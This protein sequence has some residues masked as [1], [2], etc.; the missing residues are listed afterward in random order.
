MGA[1]SAGTIRWSLFIFVLAADCGSL[2][3]ANEPAQQWNPPS[4]AGSTQFPLEVGQAENL[5]H[6]GRAEQ[7]YALLYPLEGQFAGLPVYDFALARAALRSGRSEEGQ[8]LLHRVVTVDPR[9]AAAWME[10]AA[11]D[12]E[13]RDATALWLKLRT[14][15]SLSPPPMAGRQLKLWMQSLGLQ[16]ARSERLDVQVLGGSDS[17]ANLGTGLTEFGDI[18]I[19]ATSRATPSSFTDYSLLASLQRPAEWPQSR[20]VTSAIRYRRYGADLA[21]QLSVALSGNQQWIFPDRVWRLGLSGGQYRSGNLEALSLST[22]L[23]REWLVS[24][25]GRWLLALDLTDLNFDQT[26][27]ARSRLRYSLGGG[28]RQATANGR[29]IADCMVLAYGERPRQGSSPFANHGAMLHAAW[30]HRLAPGFLLGLRLEFDYRRYRQDA[31]YYEGRLRRDRSARAELGLSWALRP[32]GRL[33]LELQ[34]QWRQRNS[35]L[36][37]FSHE[38]GL[39]AAGLN[40]SLR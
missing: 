23:T 9:H 30:R 31:D 12:A 11:L 10:L 20:S 40:W 17:N 25:T 3:W 29:A 39:V 28:R 34:G 26:S 37:V 2:A 33:S 8:A 24:P 35:S 7:A 21:P 18:E 19:D 38:A 5:L 13:K 14:L 27:E 6:S 4:P 36:D 22:R 1:T 15:A 32:S 16:E